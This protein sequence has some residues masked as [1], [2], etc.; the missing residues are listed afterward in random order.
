MWTRTTRLVSA[1]SLTWLLA[2]GG[3]FAQTTDVT[4][5]VLD[6]LALSP[7]TIDVTASDQPIVVTLAARDDIAGLARVRVE[8]RVQIPGLV[9]QYQE[10]AVS[11]GTFAGDL[12]VTMPAHARAGTWGL[13]ITLQDAVG[14]IVTL[15]TAALSARGFPSEVTVAC[16]DEDITPPDAI[17]AQILPGAVDVS[18][19]STHVVAR[20]RVR[21]DR[22]G[23]WVDPAFL[24]YFS[25]ILASPTG[26][27]VRRFN[28]N[29]QHVAGD[30]MNGTW[31]VPLEIPRY[32]ESGVWAL[33]LLRLADR[34][35]NVRYLTPFTTPAAPPAPLAVTSTP[36][37]LAPPT[38]ASLSVVP[39]VIDTSA[40]DQDVT[41]TLGLRDDLSGL[42]FDRESY[43]HRLWY[44]SP[45]GQQLR[46]LNRTQF[47]L[48]AGNALD[49]VW[50]SR[51]R[52]PRFSE[53]G[54]WR[55][56]LFRFEDATFNLLSLNG[57]AL[58]ALPTI[59]VIRPSLEA[60]GIV[61]PS[62][63]TVEDA[64]FGKRASMS[65]PSGALTVPT[66]VA[67]DVLDSSLQLPMPAGFEAA[68]TRYV[69]ITLTPPP[70][71]PL[72]APG[73]RVVLPLRDA[74]PAGTALPLARIDPATGALVPAIGVDGGPVVGLVD[75]S[76]L[77][78]TF[79]GI[80]RLSTVVGLVP[81]PIAV[82]VD[83]RPGE[84]DNPINRA[85]GG[86]LPVAILG[87]TALEVAQIDAGTIR[88]GAAAPW[89]VAT[90]DLN[91]DGRPDLIIHVRIQSL[92]LEPDAQAV[93]V[94]AR[95]TDGWRLRGSDAVRVVR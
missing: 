52:F 66:E 92:Q 16:L 80:A 55:V 51:L 46:T 78:A 37:D 45:S 53:A 36:S 89:H 49:G 94:E 3:A 5:P 40:A 8:L 79:E 25:L 32:A 71:Y 9:P 59:T 34:A 95:T 39:A 67:I 10:T 65:V 18:G 61:G 75:A 13:S 90:D 17:D 22:S 28:A 26:Q 74:L 72:P 27:E 11:G 47:V 48:R 69:N 81:A 56:S 58:T 60:D 91:A 15:G 35:G 82:A 1:A 14:N 76:G 21:D 19:A 30:R 4:P 85:A 84:P 33:S 57:P 12:T 63:G 41:V 2:Q 88:V 83:V 68:G 86:L 20:L 70:A 64:T 93:V 7:S 50:E 77:S 62:G 73:I 54:T 6:A 24:D 42:F 23:V 44:R 31:E 38:V 87:T 29:F 43:W